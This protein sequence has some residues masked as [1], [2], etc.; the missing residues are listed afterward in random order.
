MPAS[1]GCSSR[2]TAYTASQPSWYGLYPFAL[3]VGTKGPQ[4]KG[5][6]P[7]TALRYAEGQRLLTYDVN[8]ER[9][10]VHVNPLGELLGASA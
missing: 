3:S 10:F 1:H 8:E 7:S 6:R 5:E 9:G 4:S 2:F